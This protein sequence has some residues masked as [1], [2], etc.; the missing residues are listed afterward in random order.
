MSMSMGPGAG[1]NNIT[2]AAHN[3]KLPLIQRIYGLLTASVIFAVVCG[4]LMM[5]TPS[6]GQLQA[7]DGSMV[8]VPSGVVLMRNFSLLIWIGLFGLLFLARFIRS[9]GA[10]IVLVFAFCGLAGAWIAPNVFYVSALQGAPELVSLAGALTTIMFVT[11]T[12]YAML[13]K[14]SF[15]FLGAGISVAFIGLMAASLLNMFFFKSGFGFTVI[16]WGIL[17][18]ASACVLYDTWRITQDP[19]LDESNYAQ[20]TLSLFVD[21]LNMFMAIL[22]LLSGSRR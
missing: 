4:A 22:S 19:H 17:L 8:S 21:L 9:Q 20:A 11:L 5:Q 10:G 14:T 12:A 18:F 3:N 15:N 2:A 1:Y 16:A 13:S 7:A 6:A